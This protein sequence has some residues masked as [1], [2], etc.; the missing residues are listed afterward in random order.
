MQ[1]RESAIRAR[2]Y[3]LWEKDGSTHGRHQD[4]WHQAEREIDENSPVLQPPAPQMGTEDVTPS[5]VPTGSEQSP[6]E[7][8]D[9][10]SDGKTDDADAQSGNRSKPTELASKAAP[11]FK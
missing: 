8:R 1:D 5:D 9:D 4:H 6:T 3:D 7:P 2:A 11:R 10:L